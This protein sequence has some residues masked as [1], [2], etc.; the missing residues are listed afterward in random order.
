MKLKL[1]PK[2]F[3]FVMLGFFILL[4]VGGGAAVYFAN[5][6]MQKHSQDVVALKLNNQKLDE[7]VNAYHSA[8]ADLKKYQDLQ[9]LVARVVPTEKDQAGIVREIVTLAAENG[10]Q[11]ASVNFPTSSLGAPGSTSTTATGA[12]GTTGTAAKPTITQAKPVQGLK[13]V[14]AIQTSVTPLVDKD[15]VITY[16]QL[17]NFLSKLE[18]NRRTM[19]IT[20]LQVTPQGIFTTSGITFQLTVNIFV[21]P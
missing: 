9:D 20:N 19:Q 18:L 12:A 10:I 15:H 8:Q 6:L 13:G 7:Q 16:A 1:T 21:K 11:I 2:L 3:F 17:L 14:Y 5:G 4:L